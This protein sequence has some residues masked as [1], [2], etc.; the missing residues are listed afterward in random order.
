[1][2]WGSGLA[3]VLAAVLAVFLDAKARR[4]EAWLKEVYPEYTIYAQQVKRLVPGVY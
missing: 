4:E 2:I 3:L 1:L